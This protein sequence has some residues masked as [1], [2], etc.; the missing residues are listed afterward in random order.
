MKTKNLNENGIFHV[1]ASEG[2]EKI[3]CIILVSTGIILWVSFIISG[4]WILIRNGFAFDFA[5]DAPGVAWYWYVIASIT[6]I[7]LIRY[8]TW[9]SDFLSGNIQYQ[10]KFFTFKNHYHHGSGDEYLNTNNPLW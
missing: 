9:V 2:Q 10:A 4:G 1:N 3:R 5:Y 6:A 7:L 8:H